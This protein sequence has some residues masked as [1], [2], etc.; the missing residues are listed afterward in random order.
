MKNIELKHRQ[1]SSISAHD[2]VLSCKNL[3]VGY[4]DAPVIDN[5]N[6]SFKAGE[7]VALLGPNG[8]GKTTFLRTLSRHLPPLSG[9]ISLQGKPLASLAQGEL[10]RIIA[11]VL[12]DKISPPLFTAFDFVALGRYPH[13]GFL[14][15]L[16]EYDRQVV[17]HA[18]FAVH[19]DNLK[20]RD[21]AS[22]SDGERQKVLVARALAQEP[23]I[24]LLD[25]PTAHLDLK[26]KMEVMAILR[27]L[28]RSDNITVIAS[29]HDVDIAA[30]VSD[31]VALIKDGSVTAWGDPEK[32]LTDKSVAELY[33]FDAACFSHHL[34]SIELRSSGRERRGKVFVIGGMGMGTPVYRL[35]AKRGYKFATGVIYENDLDYFVAG[36][37]AATC[38]SQLPAGVI[39]DEAIAEA[40]LAIEECDMV[41][42]AGISADG[43]Y[44]ENLVLLNRA[45]E[46]GKPVFML[47]P[48]GKEKEPY[49]NSPFLFATINELLD[50]MEKIESAV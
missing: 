39:G 21:F 26:H 40:V 15:R 43:P 16:N 18:L 41:I 48:K 22:L 42:D 8:A 11:V 44:S 33:D 28:C 24:L 10:A 5:I 35:L 50:A 46:L 38:I 12:T 13:T 17:S 4:R 1:F 19:A 6:L 2:T 45:G 20:G 25:E 29:L 47:C 7:F 9:E 34:G 30:R 14:G 31:R 27:D 32:I 37:L 23:E 3:L 36:S 49:G